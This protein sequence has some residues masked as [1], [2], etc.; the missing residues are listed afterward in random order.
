MFQETTENFGKLQL[1]PAFLT[2]NDSLNLYP[3][4][5]YTRLKPL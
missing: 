4:Y 1:I 3:G 5:S 2:Y